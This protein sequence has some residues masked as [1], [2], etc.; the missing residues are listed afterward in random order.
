MTDALLVVVL[1]VL[2]ASTGWAGLLWLIHRTP[3]CRACVG[4]AHSTAWL[5]PTC[6]DCGRR[7]TDTRRSA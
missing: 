1:Y 6:T 3:R 5:A 7:T 2:A 4:L